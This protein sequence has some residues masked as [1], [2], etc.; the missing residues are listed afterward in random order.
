MQLLA[1]R[2]QKVRDAPSEPAT[3]PL[4]VLGAILPRQRWTLRIEAP[5]TLFLEE[6]IAAG[7]PCIGVSG[8]DEQ[9]LRLGL[10][11]RASLL[12]RGVEAYIQRYK[13]RGDGTSDVTLLG[14]RLFDLVA[15]S[16]L[17]STHGRCV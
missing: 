2:I 1:R 9:R 12:P 5:L 15:I 11:G 4:V 16:D 13:P 7:Q 3:L 6:Q 8:A 17:N 10:G 14:T